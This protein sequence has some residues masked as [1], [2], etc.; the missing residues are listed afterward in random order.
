M[1][2]LELRL[3]S[4]SLPAQRSLGVFWDLETDAFTVKVSTPAVQGDE[5]SS[6]LNN[7]GPGGGENTCRAK[8]ATKVDGDAAGPVRRR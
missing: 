3:D 7:F 4:F 6:L 2:D 1:R 5:S 8:A